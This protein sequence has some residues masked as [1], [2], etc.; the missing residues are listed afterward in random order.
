MFEIVRPVSHRVRRARVLAA[1]RDGQLRRQ[2]ACDADARLI[3][4]ARFHGRVAGRA[5]PV[6][7][8]DQLREVRFVYGDGLGERA[9]T[10]RGRRELEALVA[11]LGEVGVHL[12]EVC[13]GCGWNH[14]LGSGVAVPRS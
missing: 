1:L 10:A 14:L 11:E 2:A 8:S 5:C 4:A 13:P 12:V 9:G 6:C 7:G 3:A